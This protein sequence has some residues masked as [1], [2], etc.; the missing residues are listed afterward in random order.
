MSPDLCVDVMSDL[1]DSSGMV[2]SLRE[3]L[4]RVVKAG[5][6]EQAVPWSITLEIPSGP[7]AVLTV[8]GKQLEDFI[9][10]AGDT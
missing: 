10:G 7:E 9:M 5:V 6:I 4:N 1:F 2:Q 3:S 8:C